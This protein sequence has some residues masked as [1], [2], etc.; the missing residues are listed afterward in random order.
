MGAHLNKFWDASY[1]KGADYAIRLDGVNEEISSLYDLFDFP[2]FTIHFWFRLPTLPSVDGKM[3]VGQWDGAANRCYGLYLNGTNQLTIA[4]SSNGSALTTLT[5]TY[6][7]TANTWYC[8]T[9]VYDQSPVTAKLYING[10]QITMTGTPVLIFNGTGVLRY[11]VNNGSSL[12]T[13]VDFYNFYLKGNLQSLSDHQA[14]YNSGEKF[15]P[16]ANGETII[17]TALDQAPSLGATLVM[18]LGSTHTNV[19]ME[20]T[21]VI[22][23]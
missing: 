10:A 18:R 19:Y 17:W 4:M 23:L 15:N 9:L 3:I 13:A 21:D 2:E 16:E 22:A 8:C 12:Y 6:G 14:F 11:G 7:L 20:S 1:L 5:T